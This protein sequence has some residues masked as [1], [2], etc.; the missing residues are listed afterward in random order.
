M[1]KGF[2]LIEML[3]VI[4]I[5]ALLTAL[6]SFNFNQA[7]ARSRDIQRK[8]DMKQLQSALEAYKNDYGYYPNQASLSGLNTHLLTISAS[9]PY[10]KAA[11]KDPKEAQSTNSWRDYT[12][13]YTSAT[14]YTLYA[15]LEI[16][17][18]PAATGGSCG[19]GNSGKYYVLTQP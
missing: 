9:F 17:S 8:S 16:R 2:T 19:P 1:K 3:V 14:Q 13:T 10:I 4:G 12:Y 7:R 18:D 11:F 6:A 15:C 5:M